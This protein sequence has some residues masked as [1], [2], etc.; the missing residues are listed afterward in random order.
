M[1]EKSIFDRADFEEIAW[2]LSYGIEEYHQDVHE[3]ECDPSLL[4]L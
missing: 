4:K 3:E 2:W 1:S